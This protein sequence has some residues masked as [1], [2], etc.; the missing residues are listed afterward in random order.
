MNEREGKEKI[1]NHHMMPNMDSISLLAILKFL[2]A[3]NSGS[4]WEGAR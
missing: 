3:S 2:R 1:I 4:S